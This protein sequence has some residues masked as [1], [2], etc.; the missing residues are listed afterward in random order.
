MSLSTIKRIELLLLCLGIS[1]LAIF[2][3]GL[4]YA[5]F[6]QEYYD[7][8]F[9]RTIRGEAAPVFDFVKQI[10]APGSDRETP[11]G[12]PTPDRPRRSSASVPKSAPPPG[13]PIG[14]LEIPSLDVSAMV[15]EGTNGMTLARGVGRIEGTAMPGMSGNVGLA[16]HRDSFFR[17]LRNI[18][19]KDLIILTTPEG[20]YRYRVTKTRV[21]QPSETSVLKATPEP[22]LTLVTCYP[23]YFVGHAPRRFIV[24]ARLVPPEQ[25]P[26]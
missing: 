17:P 22:V 26:R 3:A 7:W 15:L 14:R 6:S 8:A 12:Q 18:S 13:T 25:P 24:Q 10:V 5:R 11:P 16:A 20:T 1:L 21:V 2:A 19:D 9:E 4:A 23:F